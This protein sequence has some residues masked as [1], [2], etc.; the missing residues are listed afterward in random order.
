MSYLARGPIWMGIDSQANGMRL[1]THERS[2]SSAGQEARTMSYLTRGPIWMG[3]DSQA[4][5]M[6][7]RRQV[8]RVAQQCRR[9]PA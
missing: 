2:M 7:C 3:I 9:Q 6:R 8:V 5:G 4:N 1:L